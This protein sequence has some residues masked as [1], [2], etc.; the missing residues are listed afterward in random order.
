V[1]VR[2]NAQTVGRVSCVCVCVF[3]GPGGLEVV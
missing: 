3:G 2:F 1:S